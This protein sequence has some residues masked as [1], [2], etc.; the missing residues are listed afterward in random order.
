MTNLTELYTL[1]SEKELLEIQG[2]LFKKFPPH[3]PLHFYTGKISEIS[4]EQQQFLVKFEIANEDLSR[5]NIQ[6]DGQLTINTIEDLNRINALIDD[7]I[8]ITGIYENSKEPGQDIITILEKEKKFFE[9]RLKIYLDT[10][11]REII[12]YD[13]FEQEI[14]FDDNISEFTEE[15]Q[16]A[17]AKYYDEKR[18]RIN[19]VEEAVDFLIHEELNEDQISE[20]RNK[21]LSSK[22]DNLGGLF[23][24]GMYFRNIFIYPNKNENFIQ[25][26]KTY[27]PQYMVDRGE[28]GEGIIE[29]FLWRKLNHYVITEENKKKIAELRKEE[30]KEES[31]WSNYI[32]EQLLS[33]NLD[34]AIITEYLDLEDK[35]DTDDGNF[36]DCHYQQKRIIAGLSEDESRIFENMKQDFLT[37]QNL[38]LQ[39]KHNHE[40]NRK[41]K[42]K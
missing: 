24:Q 33:Y 19:T 22:F 17:S 6:N 10:N 12:P 32:T 27:D 1:L 13:Y 26:L 18:S 4:D 41:E 40:R 39:I 25:H 9:F 23:G 15:E 34:E 5:F 31:F 21:S 16:E 38:V 20:I 37:L 30:Y 7:K 2:N 42:N 3:F 36:M 11:S 8:K 14:D 28:F 29:D 35:K